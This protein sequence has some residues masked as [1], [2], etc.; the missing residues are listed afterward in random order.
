MPIRRG[1]PV[2]F[3]GPGDSA[4]TSMLDITPAVKLA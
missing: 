1:A 3:I 4:M 2:E